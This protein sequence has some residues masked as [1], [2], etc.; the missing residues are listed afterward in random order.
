LPDRTAS[1][2]DRAVGLLARACRRLIRATRQGS[3]ATLPGLIAERLAP[4][5][6]GRSARR[7]ERIVLVSGT[8]GKTTTTAML[9]AAMATAG[10]G[11]V[12]NAEG[13]NLARGITTALLAAGPGA[14]DAVLEVD[15]AVLPGAVAELRPVLVVLLNLSRD[16]LDRHHEISA[17][18]ARWRVALSTLPP[19]ATVVAYAGDPRTAW[20][21]QAAGRVRAVALPAAGAAKDAGICPDCA[22]PLPR[23]AAGMPRCP[24]CSWRPPRASVTVRRLGGAVRFGGDH[25]ALGARLPVG[26][27]G[28]AL[29]AALA[30]TAACELGA[31]PGAALAA[32]A[33]LAPVQDRYAERPW[34]GRLVRLLLAKNP[35]GWDE[36]LAAASDPRRSAVVAV[37]AGTVDGRD[38]S[39][40]WDVDMRALRARPKV[41]A[42]GD[43][44]EDVAVR[45]AAAGVRC[46]LVR[47]LELAMT[48]AGG[49][50]DLFADYTSFRSARRIIGRG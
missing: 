9:A 45:L 34:H 26:T 30:W 50:I 36:A 18:A 12:S 48:A 28:Y 24:H 14:Q 29:D 33:A 27:D 16:Q 7:L 6:G 35:A 43:R 41:T 17:L 19:G 8:N 37:N 39:W 15:E 21:A 25:G 23:P 10:R 2:H 40:L 31:E 47:P 22:A 13:S 3:G 44:A 38:T 32:I 46:D 49:D 20:A 11:V 4:G 42:T 1:A 5:I